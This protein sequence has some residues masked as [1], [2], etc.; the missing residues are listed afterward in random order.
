MAAV[1]WYASQPEMRQQPG[2][3]DLVDYFCHDA[4]HRLNPPSSLSERIRRHNDTRVYR[5]S[6]RI[7]AGDFLWLEDGIL[8]V[9]DGPKK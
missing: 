6:K 4:D 7:M 2:I 5:L 9:M 3:R 8:P 1:L